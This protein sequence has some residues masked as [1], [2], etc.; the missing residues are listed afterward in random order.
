MYPILNDR[1]HLN[2][3]MK[4]KLVCPSPYPTGGACSDVAT[5]G[6]R[7][8]WQYGIFRTREQSTEWIFI[9]NVPSTQKCGSI[10]SSALCPLSNQSSIS[11]EKNALVALIFPNTPASETARP[12]SES[13]KADTGSPPM[14][15]KC[16]PASRTRDLALGWVTMWTSWGGSEWRG[17]WSSRP[18]AM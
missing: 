4:L 6:M 1:F 7:C 16:S 9:G 17:D 14:S 2:L 3:A 10:D 11:A 12:S 5:M 13:A 18:R 8:I 15:A